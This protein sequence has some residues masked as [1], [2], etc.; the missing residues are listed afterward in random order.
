MSTSVATMPNN[1]ELILI[2]VVLSTTETYLNSMQEQ[3]ISTQATADRS[4]S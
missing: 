3:T 1:Y 2:W 4:Q